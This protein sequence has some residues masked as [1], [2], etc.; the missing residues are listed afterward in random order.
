MPVTE[1][2]SAKLFFPSVVDPTAETT[3]RQSLNVQAAAETWFNHLTHVAGTSEKYNSVI[4]TPSIVGWDAVVTI[5]TTKKGLSD[6]VVKGVR[7][8][9]VMA[10]FDKWFNNVA[11]MGE[12]I[13]GVPAKRMKD[14]L[15]AKKDNWKNAVAVYGFRATGETAGTKGVSVAISLLLSGDPRGP[16]ITG[17]GD[18]LV[19][20]PYDI[21][22][23]GMSQ[24]FRAAL[25]GSIIQCFV[26]GSLADWDTVVLAELNN[27]LVFAANAFRDPAKVNS[28]TLAGVSPNS[29]ILIFGGPA[30][31]I[32][33]ICRLGSP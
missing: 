25:M 21:N 11:K 2:A 30:P 9:K 17:P 10:S 8:G 3:D 27:K 18:D 1:P 14:I 22:V 7:A 33:V 4:A 19:G 32:E 23:A 26:L 13:G 5:G 31:Y 16:L 29:Q 6:A 24:M 28:F 12:E 20:M 15:E